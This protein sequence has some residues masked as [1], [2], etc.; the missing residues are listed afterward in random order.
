MKR[1]YI[2]P[3]WIAIIS[4][5]T[6][7]CSKEEAGDA[8]NG[9]IVQVGVTATL[10]NHSSLEPSEEYESWKK[11][12]PIGIFMISHGKELTL[13][14][15]LPGGM[16]KCYKSNNGTN[17]FIPEANGQTLN[18][19]SHEEMVDLFAYYPYSSSIVDFVYPIDLSDQSNQDRIDFRYSD[20]VKE[21]NSLNSEALLVFEH[22][23][24]KLY[25]EIKASSGLTSTD[26]KDLKV[27]LEGFSTTGNFSLANKEF[28]D[29]ATPQT[30]VASTALNGKTSEA[31]VLPSTSNNGRKI[32]FTLSN[33]QVKEWAIPSAMKFECSGRILFTVKLSLS[34]TPSVTYVYDKWDGTVLP[35]NSPVY[36]LLDSYKDDDGNVLGMVV[37]LDSSK[38]HGIAISIDERRGNWA[39][40]TANLGIVGGETR[41]EMQALVE[42]LGGND[43]KTKFESFAWCKEHEGENWFLP[44]LSDLESIYE[45]YNQDRNKF[46]SKLETM[47]GMRINESASDVTQSYWV[48]AAKPGVGI[49]TFNFY[50][51]SNAEGAGRTF[52][53]NTR[54]ILLF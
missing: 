45:L 26:L 24:T 32:V 13:D 20:N 10:G 5:I 6:V 49:V 22:Q 16:N 9:K 17:N 7:S 46:N 21:K 53:R 29:V 39:S 3:L 33:G 43:W 36:D 11:D 30:I 34:S 4:L 1:K 31:I 15:I 41:E 47:G 54:A 44:T 18:Y 42:K 25:F 8:P 19:P 50:D 48:A 28:T 38:K 35:D 23:F 2:Y 27:E 51:G 37:S 14:N 12:D 52:S 40:Y